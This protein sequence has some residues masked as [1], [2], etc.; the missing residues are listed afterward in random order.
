MIGAVELHKLGSRNT[1]GKRQPLIVLTGLDDESVA[2][3]ALQ[4][5]AQDYIIKGQIDLRGLV[6][7]LRYAV[8]RK[9]MEDTARDM[10]LQ[11]AH[12]SKHGDLTGLPNRMLLNDRIDFA[13]A[14]A[15]RHK[16]KLALLFLDIDGFKHINDSLRHSAGDKLLKSIAARL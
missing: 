7:A 14:M 9:T 1:R 11:I 6:R 3:Q 12:T 15:A 10:A 2:G 16:T 8:E 4:E 13:I 5:G